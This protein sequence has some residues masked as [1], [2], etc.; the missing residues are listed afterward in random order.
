M[1]NSEPS[2]IGHE[3]GSFPGEDLVRLVRALGRHRYVAGRLHLV[4]AFAFDAAAAADPILADA[5]AWAAR[6]L[7][8]GVIDL[9]S[10]DERLFRKATDDEIAAVLAAFWIPGPEMARARARLTA[11]L[12]RI[13]ALPDDGAVPFDETREDEVFPRLL[14]AGWELLPLSA[15]DHERHKGAIQ[16]FD[17]FEV[18]RFEEENSADPVVT[19]CELPLIGARE[20]LS[21]PAS[22]PFVIWTE[23]H[24][25]Y[26]DYVLRGV[27]KSAKLAARD[28]AAEVG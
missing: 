9:D 5:A 13:D 3:I 4:H 19:L 1:A 8:A 14:D 2:M 7:D 20:L 15:L 12:E 27:I 10:K 21:D 26:V 17:D 16:S 22:A 25:S 28:A 23:G 18:A 6:A 24:E 11:H